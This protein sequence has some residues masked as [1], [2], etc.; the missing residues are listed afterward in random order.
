MADNSKPNMTTL[1]KTLLGLSLAGFAAGFTT[2]VLW[3]FSKPVGAIFLGLFLISKML[4]KEIA[5]FNAEEKERRNRADQINGAK[6]HSPAK[7][8]EEPIQAAA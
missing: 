2:D 4:E 1:T 5:Q 3:G 8:H 7:H 6:I